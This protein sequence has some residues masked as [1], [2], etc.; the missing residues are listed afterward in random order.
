MKNSLPDELLI[1]SITENNLIKINEALQNGAD[2]LYINKET[3]NEDTPLDIAI[4]KGNI[5]IIDL[6]G[7][8]R[9]NY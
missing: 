4:K 8:I 7:I 3:G 6:T 2:P 1:A 5:E 9:L